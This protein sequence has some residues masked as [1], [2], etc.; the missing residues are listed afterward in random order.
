MKRIGNLWP[1]IIDF[2]NLYQAAQRAQKGKRYC[3]NVLRFNDRLGD[4]LLE[5]QHELKTQTYEPGDYRT[6]KI[7]EPKPRLISAAPYRDRVVHHALCQIIGPVFERT[8]ISDSYANR[9][10]YGTH[11][12]LQRFKHFYHQNA[13]ILQCDIRK[14]FPS[15]DH[16]ILKETIRRK[17]KCPTTLW[18]IDTIIDHSN[19]QEQ[20][21]NYFPGDD[22][23]SPLARRHGLPIGNLTSQHFAN[24]YLNEFDHFIKETLRIKHYIRFVDDFACFSHEVDFL[25]EVKHRI[26]NY[27]VALRL[28][29]HPV[30]SQIF[31]T[32]LGANFLGFRFLPD[33]IRVRS[34]NLRRSTKRLR[35]QQR[36]FKQHQIT[37]PEISNSIRSWLAHLDQA[38]TWN[39]RDRIFSRL[40]FAR[41]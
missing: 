18:L 32:R 6:F 29:I 40:V 35:E 21:L 37:I 19:E 24:I 25:R 8:F 14:Y 2:G 30:K 26:E 1:Q 33:R 10:G 11:R 27:L 13:Y 4:E 31:E 23:F 38:N 5:L 7:Y 36:L 3:P 12:A 16:D 22:L 34:Q 20:V 15:I 39:L 41:G 17:I 9:V 28:K